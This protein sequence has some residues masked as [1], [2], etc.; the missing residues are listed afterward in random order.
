MGKM[1]KEKTLLKAQTIAA[2]KIFPDLRR[3]TKYIAVA[4]WSEEYEKRGYFDGA[5]YLAT[6]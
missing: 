6:H 1:V 4:A 5:S 3:T 2:K